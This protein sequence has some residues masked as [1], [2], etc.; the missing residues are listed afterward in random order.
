M[1]KSVLDSL[2]KVHA[3]GDELS[4]KKKRGLGASAAGAPAVAVGEMVTKSRPIRL[5]RLFG[6]MC[7]NVDL[8]DAKHEA[9]YLDLVRKGMNN[10][11]GSPTSF[12]GSSFALPFSWSHMPDEFANSA[13]GLEAKS[14]ALYSTMSGI[15]EYDPDQVTWLEGKIAVGMVRKSAGNMSSTDDSVGGALVGPPTQGELIPLMR[16]KAVLLRA[17]A[18]TAPFAQSG[19]MVFP[20]ETKAPV[21]FWV[22]ENG[23]SLTPEVVGTG[24]VTAQA[25][26]LRTAVRIPNELFRFASVAADAMVQRSMSTSLSLALDWAGLYGPGS[27]GAP[28]GIKNY[29]QTNEIFDY[30]SST[31]APA[32]VTANGNTLKAEDG[33]DML[34]VLEDRN[35]ELDTGFKWIMRG[36][37]FS[38]VRTISADALSAGD[39]AGAFKTDRQRAT[40]Y[41]AP[42]EWSGYE[43]VTSSQVATGYTKGTSGA[44]LTEI[45]GG[46]WNYCMFL[47]HGALEIN[48]DASG[49]TLRLADQTLFTAT[50]HS[51]VVYQYPGAF[52][53]YKNLKVTK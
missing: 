5:T 9:K 33:E 49:Q 13:E 20:R 50:L 48:S 40:G 45:F 43:V 36:R 12:G 3:E 39:E 24:T 23:N 35:F 16:N 34:G 14:M 27:N 6:L 8:N 38:R 51:D 29:G 1:A 31:P 32:G 15:S 2:D 26:K 11:G 30:E 25:K 37:M 22:P 44:T 46:M 7:G 28:L 4:S 18:Q 53:I 42:R 52:C 47:M 41:R 17:G 21:A 19:R 10:A